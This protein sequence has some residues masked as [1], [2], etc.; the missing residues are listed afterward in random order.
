MGRSSRNNEEKVSFFA[1]QDIIT[2]VIGILVLI[3][4][5]LAL[6]VN[7]KRENEGDSPGNNTAP[8]ELIEGVNEGGGNATIVVASEFNSTQVMEEIAELHQEISEE[9]KEFLVQREKKNSEIEVLSEELR[10]LNL[11]LKVFKKKLGIEDSNESKETKEKIESLELLMDL[12]RVQ[13]NESD[14]EKKGLEDKINARVL[15]SLK[16]LSELELQELDFNLNAQVEQLE[17]QIENEVRVIPKENDVGEKPVLVILGST[18]FTIG[19]FNGEQRTIQVNP[20]NYYQKLG[21][22]LNSYDKKKNFF[23]Y[24]F[25]PSA[26]QV[27]VT[28]VP[29]RNGTIQKNLFDLLCDPKNNLTRMLGY[30]YGFEPIHEEA[31]VLFTDKTPDPFVEFFPNP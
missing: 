5:I 3:A 16:N 4:L 2:A 31:A 13:K 7:P 15:R 24:F 18:E 19:I 28:N 30:K 8:V 20:A 25:R 22:S 6:Q 12:A 29:G 17:S 27:T 23:V 21:G 10:K 11:E 14:I 1:F 26:C 9:K